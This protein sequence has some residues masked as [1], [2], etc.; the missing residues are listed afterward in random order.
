V[1]NAILTGLIITKIQRPARLRY[2]IEF[3]KVGVINNVIPT[4]VMDNKDWLPT[5]EYKPG[6]MVFAF[7]IFNLRKRLLCMPELRLF[8]LHKS[9]Y[10]CHYIIM[11]LLLYLNKLHNSSSKT[12]IQ[13]YRNGI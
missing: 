6:N 3:S 5:G 9:K 10:L 4:F 11:I 2:T 1:V 13:N 8:L 12:R 7:R